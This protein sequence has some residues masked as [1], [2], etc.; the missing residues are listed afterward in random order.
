MANK[1]VGLEDLRAAFADTRTVSALGVIKR[2]ALLSDRSALRVLVSL[3][4]EG[5]QIVATMTWEAVGPEAGI[6]DFPAVGDLVLV[7]F[8]DKD[9]DSAFVTRRLT[10][11]TDKIPL[12]ATEGHLVMQAKDG[13]EVYVAGSK[14]NLARRN[15]IP[16]EPVPL[17][18]V[19]KTML[20]NEID[21]NVEALT[22]IKTGPLGL[23]NLGAP[24]MPA[25]A[26]V[27][28]LN[29]VI[30][31]LN[32]IKETYITTAGTNIVSQVAFTE[33]GA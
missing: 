15:Q 27:A 17:G 4:P 20:G 6:F 10:S 5:E 13:K 16:T 11:K 22:A 21:K 25:P 1:N 9:P 26:L 3:F 30:E 31:S 33:R 12:K 28:T 14:V 32:T 23:G 19:L 29:G 8:V 18:N 2:L 7:E 24:V